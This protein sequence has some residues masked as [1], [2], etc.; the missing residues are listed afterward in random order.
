[1][2]GKTLEDVVGYMHACSRRQVT[3]SR[4]TRLDDESACCVLCAAAFT[5]GFEKMRGSQAQRLFA[6]LLD[7]GVRTETDV[8]SWLG[9]FF[10]PVNARRWDACRKRA[11]QLLAV[12]MEVLRPASPFLSNPYDR[13]DA[14]RCP[15]V[16]FGK[17]RPSD[18]PRFAVFNSRKPRRVAPD[19]VWLDVLRSSLHT[20]DR[21]EIGLVGSIG[22]LTY[23]LA[24]VLAQR[25]GFLQL[26]VAP[27]P[28]IE[29]EHRFLEIFGEDGTS[30]VP[31]L[32]CMLDGPGCPAKQPMRCRDRLLAGLSDFHLVLEIRSGGNLLSIL[33][34]IQSKSPR[35]Q[36]IVKPVPAGSSNGGNFILLKDFPEHAIA[37]ESSAPQA[38]LAADSVRS[39]GEASR[40]ANSGSI[41][42][43]EYLY[44]YTRA[45]SGPWPGETYRQYLLELLDDRPG[46]DRSALEVLT[47]IAREGL[48]RADSRMVRGKTTV[49]CWSSL[50]PHELFVMRKWRRGLRRWTV[51][52]YGV[53]VRRDV[54]RSLGAK[55]AI[56][57]S[58]ELYSKLPEAEKFRFQLSRATPS[59]SWRHEREWRL[60][61]DLALGQLKPDEC[62]FFVQT[63]QEAERLY[64]LTDLGF[65]V[66]AIESIEPDSG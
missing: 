36:F 46:S 58:G 10:S 64:G 38:A 11:E 37:F 43:S 51:E 65:P 18:R 52:P 7:A 27:F 13:P 9:E 23:D 39:S 57:G 42:W 21:R 54:L 15:A 26:M 50:P 17:G 24:S 31:V 53:A 2:D 19:A 41:S 45:G 59:A 55:P 63:A 66:F 12:G 35:P 34:Q 33:E 62:F 8:R 48:L 29:T 44:H 16:L 3:S 22:T 4:P 20:V 40:L 6:N 47:R 60:A 14:P 5:G 25:R 49:I 32:S 28:L 30:A 56:Y 1:M 61:G